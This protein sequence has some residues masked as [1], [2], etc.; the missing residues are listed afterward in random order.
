MHNLGLIGGTFDRFHAGHKK[1]IDNALEKCK[2][3][4]I[5]IVSDEIARKNNPLTMKWENRKKD[6]VSNLGKDVINKIKFGIL[7]NQFG[8]APKHPDATAIICTAETVDMC[9]E[10]NKMRRETRLDELEI[11]E[12]EHENAWDGF[13]ISSTRI[14]NG[15]INRQGESWIRPYFNYSN[16]NEDTE[17]LVMTEYAEEML[18]IP[19]GVLIDGKEDDYT[20]AMKIM[21]EKYSNE[22]TPLITVGDVTTLALQELNHC[23]DISLIDGKTKRKIWNQA[24][25]IDIN[26]YDNYLKCVNPAGSLTKSLLNSCKLALEKWLIDKSTSI[27]D[28]EGEEDLAPLIIH[29]VAPL[30]AI[31][32]YGQPGKG[33]VVRKTEEESKER[34]KDIL[35]KFIYS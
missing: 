33:V 21:M 28:V 6:I 34:C 15:E 2:K 8:P 14:R 13:P 22:N 23:A 9:V 16:N 1:L 5:W 27:I 24:S 35:S 18:K 31:I 32:V 29:L 17:S 4:E 26:K 10:I 7:E 11:I 3:I 19:Y 25:D 30:G 12:V 20:Y